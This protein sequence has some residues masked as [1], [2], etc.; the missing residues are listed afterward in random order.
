MLIYKVL[1]AEQWAQCQKDGWFEGAQV[2]L[3]DG[4]VHFSTAS[5]VGET[6]QRHFHGVAGLFIAATDTDAL[7]DALKWEPSRGGALFPHLYR[8]LFLAEIIWAEPLELDANG[9]HR[10]PARMT[11]SGE[12]AAA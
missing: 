3:A 6:L 8:M 12:G 5:Q 7:D 4:F 1:T 11:A 2:D 9:Q 10:L